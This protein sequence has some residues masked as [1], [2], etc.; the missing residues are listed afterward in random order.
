MLMTFHYYLSLRWLRTP[1]PHLLDDNISI[2]LHT[3]KVQSSL[4][5]RLLSMLWTQQLMWSIS[6]GNKKLWF[7]IVGWEYHKGSKLWNFYPLPPNHPRGAA[8]AEARGRG[9]PLRSIAAGDRSEEIHC[10]VIENIKLLKSSLLEVH[11]L[12]FLLLLTFFWVL[13]FI[14]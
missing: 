8:A 13:T 14:S 11:C 4:S 12:W 1:N 7:D 10:K 5:N 6:I 3:K 2:Y 9:W